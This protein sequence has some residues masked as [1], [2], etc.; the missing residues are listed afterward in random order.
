MTNKQE[1]RNKG[2]CTDQTPKAWNQG[3]K[4]PECALDIKKMQENKMAD[5]SSYKDKR[6]KRDK[7]TI[8]HSRT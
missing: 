6:D 5:F 2:H 4:C 8:T 1:K 7:N 3:P